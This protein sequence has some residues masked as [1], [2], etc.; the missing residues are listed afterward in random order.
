M[1]E[2]DNSRALQMGSKRKRVSWND[3]VDKKDVQSDQSSN[4]RLRLRGP[5]DS[6][7][8][9]GKYAATPVNV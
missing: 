1:Y 9:S 8:S 6:T 3:K 5:L 2:V 4:R 7:F